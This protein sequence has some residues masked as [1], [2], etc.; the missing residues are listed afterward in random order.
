VLVDRSCC[1]SSW[2]S[3]S[4]LSDYGVPCFIIISVL[5][6]NHYY[7]CFKGEK[8]TQGKLG[9]PGRLGDKVLLFPSELAPPGCLSDIFK[10][11]II[12]S[13]FGLCFEVHMYGYVM[14]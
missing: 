5:K 9:A 10:T 14:T 7:Q 6:E 13:R 3:V 12:T 4:C 11:L 8:V 2:F 1:C